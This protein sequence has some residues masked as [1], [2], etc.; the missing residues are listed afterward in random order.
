LAGISD[1]KRIVEGLLQPGFN[2]A[3]MGTSFKCAQM[4]ADS[5]LPLRCFTAHN[6]VIL[7]TLCR[8]TTTLAR[9]GHPTLSLSARAHASSLA[10]DKIVSPFPDFVQHYASAVPI[11]ARKVIPITA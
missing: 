9:R 1:A 7:L 3:A 5:A 11:R 4:V 6:K 10:G 8:L 2:T